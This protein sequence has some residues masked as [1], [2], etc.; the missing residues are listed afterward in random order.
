MMKI[1]FT[2]LCIIFLLMGASAQNVRITGKIIDT[3]SNS[4]V[5]EASVLLLQAKDSILVADTRSLKDG[6]FSLN[7]DKKGQYILLVTY[8]KYIE[9]FEK[10]RI[11]SLS[12][13]KHFNKINLTRQEILL[14]EVMVK[15][16]KLAPM[17]MNGDTLE[18]AADSFHVQ[19]NASVED[20]LKKLPGLNIDKDGKITA[21][22]KTVNKVLVDGEEFFGDDPTLVTKN[23]KANMVDKVQVF[24]KTSDQAAFTGISDGVKTKTLNIKLKADKKQGYFGKIEAAGGTKGFYQNQSM[25]NLFQGEQ[26]IAGYITH[27]NTGLIGLDRRSQQSYA[28]GD[29]NPI[30]NDLDNWNGTYS[31]V[32]IPKSVS[33]GGHYSDKWNEGKEA[34]NGNYKLGS[35]DILGEQNTISQI[36]LPGNS[37]YQNSTHTTKNHMLR[38]G[39]NMS[40]NIKLDPSSEL[41]FFLESSFLNKKTNDHDSTGIRRENLLKLNNSAKDIS[42]DG[43]VKALNSNVL[44]Q[45]K[46]NKDRRTLS[47]NFNT[48]FNNSKSNGFFFTKSDFFDN[49]GRIDSS[50]VIDQFKTTDN[51]AESYGLKFTYTE[52]LSKSGSLIVNYGNFIDKAE[53][54]LY[55]FNKAFANNYSNTPDTLYTNNY[56]FNQFSS[57]GGIAYIYDQQKIHIQLSTDMAYN[58]FDQHNLFKNSTLKRSF[59]NWFPN[60][61]FRYNISPSKTIAFDYNGYNTQPAIQQLQPVTNNNDPLNIFI[62]NTTLR[63]TFTNSFASSYQFIRKSTYLSIS[64]NFSSTNNPIT[65][66]TRTDSSGK[67][68]NTYINFDG[69]ATYNYTANFLFREKLKS[70]DMDY[71]LDGGAEGARYAGISNGLPYTSYTNAYRMNAVLS[72]SKNNVYNLGV[73]AGVNYSINENDLQPLINN[74]SWGYNIY[75]FFDFYLPLKIQIHSDGNY[76]WQGKTQT[77]NQNFSRLLW[78]A[79]IGKQMLKQS[80]LMFKLSVNDI[81]NQNIGFN[82]SVNNN[83]IVQNNYTTIARY[84]L[85]SLIWDFNHTLKNAK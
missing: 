77:F 80:N 43:N 36:S 17:R 24:D 22:G 50:Q 1:L 16:T 58:Q 4:P 47:I 11:D 14:K 82:R 44:W 28:S 46:L 6:A 48:K 84:F 49:T 74:N 83:S 61:Q 75:P 54:A 15:F 55:T 76:T 65:L 35:L 59:N 45:K 31:G 10:F 21:Q 13:E 30:S 67:T 42:T 37:I 27:S 18:F 23:L 81:L 62:G 52:P 9:Y 5:N 66:S 51:S 2:F 38:H 79:W 71:G 64:G 78:N 63:P 33:G 85:V 20:L 69:K 7:V 32:G 70:W 56:Q 57:R 53:S 34:F 73:M 72:K 8:P 25:F 68:T 26:K 3:V 40:Y 39:L 29:S 19:L 41:K 60:A 12:A